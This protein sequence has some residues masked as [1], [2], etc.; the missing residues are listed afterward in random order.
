MRV[1]F[2]RWAPI[3]TAYLAVL[4]ATTTLL[5]V[6]ST[7]F[8]D[9]LL[10]DLST[11]LHQL[12]RQ[13]IR[14]LVGSAFWLDGWWDLC[15][16]A[17][18]LLAVLAPVERRL[19]SRRTLIAFAIGHIGA[20]L[21][22]AIGLVIALRVGAVNPMIER[23]RDVGVSY[24]FLTVAAL[25][26]YLLPRLVRVPYVALLAGFVVY[27]VATSGTFTDFGHLTAVAIGLACYPLARPYASGRTQAHRA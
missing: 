3:T 20:T 10:F 2:I 6:T 5:S 24:G 25:A 27:V 22:V 13:P 14:A 26:T 11:N 4:A 15:L 8:G 21:V 12:A 23:A 7:R 9:R 19:G 1:R 18:L 17:M 16:W